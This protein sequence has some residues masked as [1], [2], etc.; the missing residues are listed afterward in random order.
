MR[1]FGRC[2][3]VAGLCWFA[4]AFAWTSLASATITAS[5]INSPANGSAFV[6]NY[7]TGG[8]SVLVKGTV[9]GASSGDAVDIYCYFNSDNSEDKL[10]TGVSA[11]SGSFAANV[12]LKGAAANIC[13]LRAIPSGQPVPTGSAAGS[14]TGPVIVVDERDSSF[15]PAQGNLYDYYV[16]AAKPAAGFD[17]DS[18]GSCEVDDSYLTNPATLTLASLHYCNAWLPDNNGDPSGSTRSSTQVNGQDAYAPGALPGLWDESGFIPLS[19]TSSFDAAQGTVTVQAT[20]T[21]MACNAP[22]TYPPSPANCPSFHSTGV[23]EKSI[24]T[25]ASGGHVARVTQTFSNAN[26]KAHVLDLL[27][28]QDEYSADN[29]APG[30]RFPGQSAFAS[31]AA[32]Y[33]FTA[34]PSGPSSIF[35]IGDPNTTPSLSN[36]IGAITYSRRPQSATFISPAGA[37]AAVFLMHY[38]VKVPASGSVTFHWAFSDAASRGAE[39][40]LERN[41]RK[42]MTG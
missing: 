8:G 27:F 31:R 28:W 24:V 12:S 38:H 9:T 32:P 10:A 3:A 15:S 13:R 4:W 19:Y 14:F 5:N 18:L 35:V 39:A 42:R 41:E 33:S 2:A 7:D 22:A 17:F 16:F 23:R 34:F 21:L 26:G 40:Q 1:R 20:Q 36:P 37:N 29:T 11:S 6:Y 25:T 30:F